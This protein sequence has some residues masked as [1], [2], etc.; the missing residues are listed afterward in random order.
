MESP[1][2]ITLYDENDEPVKTYTRTKI[3]WGMFKKALSLQNLDDKNMSDEDFGKISG[4]VC[5][6]FGNQFSKK[7]LEDGA[8]VSEI[9]AVF[10]SV[11]ARATSIMQSQG[12]LLPNAAAGSR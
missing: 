12:M 7:Q 4:F 3:K 9:F 11:F 1:I 6:L 5:E 8:D 10:Q 2:E